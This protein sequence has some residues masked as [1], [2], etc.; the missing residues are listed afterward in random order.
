MS[1]ETIEVVDVADRE[2]YEITVDGALAGYC[3]HHERDGVM[4]LPHTVVDPRYRGRGLAA[5]LVERALADARERGLKVAP[6]CWYVAQYIDE[7][8]GERDLLAG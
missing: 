4:V 5:R 3:D 6:Q 7:H 2:R 1:T 8:P